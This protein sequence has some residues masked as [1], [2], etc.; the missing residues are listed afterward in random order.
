MKDTLKLFVC[1]ALC[2][3][4]SSR[5]LGRQAKET[6]AVSLVADSTF[7]NGI[8][9]RGTNS[10]N[11]VTSDTFKPFSDALG[12]A[13][14]MLSEWGSSHPLRTTVATG[15]D[16]SVSY[17]NEGKKITFSRSENGTGIEMEIFTSREF[18]AARKSGEDWP[19]LLL[20]QELRPQLRV[21]SITSLMLNLNAQLMY[22][23]NR[24][25][26][27][28]FD[29][30]IHTAQFS[31]YLAVNNRNRNSP[32]YGDYVWF[33]VPL[34]DYR[35]K[36]I[37]LYKAKDVGKADATGR[38]IY[39]I[40]GRSAYQGSF[41][42]QNWKHI[43][44]DLYP[45]IRK[46]FE[47]AK[48]NGYLT[49]SSWE[50]MYI[51]GMNIG[52]EVPGTFDAGLQLEGLSLVATVKPVLLK[53]RINGTPG[54]DCD[55]AGN[56]AIQDALESIHDASP[57][58]PY[59][60]D[61]GPG[62]YK[63]SQP[64]DFNSKGSSTGNYAF[65]RGK[66][67]VSLRGINKDS[68][69]VRGQLPDNL[70]SSFP[71]ESYQTVYWNARSG[72]ISNIT[73]T[74]KNIRYPVHIDG[75]AT[76]LSGAHIR[77]EHVNLLHY[78]NTGNA[79]RWKSWH[80]LG[81]GMSEGQVVEVVSSLLQSP[82]WPLYMHT[83]GDFKRAS[84]LLFSNCCFDGTGASKLLACF[85]SLGSHR[86]DMIR[87][88][89][90]TWKKGYVMQ[91]DDV[92]YLSDRKEG[93]HYDHCDLKITGRG[94]G[95]FLWSPSF[96]GQVLKIISRATEGG[97]VM[98]DTL[99]S[100]YKVIMQSPEE[101]GRQTLA[102]G[103]VLAGGYASRKGMNAVKAYARGCVDV[104][105]MPDMKNRY[106]R[107]LGKRLGNCSQ[108]PKILGIMIDGR[109]YEIIF[110][111]DYAG[112]GALND[113]I[114]PAFSNE[115]ILADI[116]DAIGNVADIALWSAG[117]NYYPA[118]TDNI[119]NGTAAEL[120]KKGMV[121]QMNSNR[122]LIPAMPGTRNILGVALDDMLPGEAGRVLT[123]GYL[124]TNNQ[125]PFH[126]L[127]SDK[128]RIEKG[129]A[130]KISPIPGILTISDTGGLFHAI[131]ENLIEI[132]N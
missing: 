114:P 86:E 13:C 41:H 36:H 53:V 11:P 3:C 39:S 125:Q 43:A 40:A 31:L 25:K 50:D 109:R 30:K 117:N 119:S 103:E 46:A 29:P 56:R 131:E 91:A 85:Q 118:F 93:I 26:S 10:G 8:I 38:F 44:K 22:C 94:N 99:S 62:V 120:I 115:K 32:G 27:Q 129:T 100:A 14:W 98:V 12:P 128:T 1:L 58:K 87:L 132:R 92:P 123:K 110:N 122:R 20:E 124:S 54:R 4:N 108:Q 63:A 23:N 107:S 106:N 45:E 75:G 60:I 34:Y 73:I 79:T 82:S 72:S 52:W 64:D 102:A 88:E 81:L 96:H 7:G 76:G 116:R 33:G 2:A 24:M 67:D 127:L 37:N 69:I 49:A 70:G 101:I 104:E 83:N 95:P 80:P 55:F 68:V 121:V 90:C 48:H 18:H 42:D 47:T 15:N 89:N 19:H 130:L 111:K 17:S 6:I 74:A 126:L 113:T 61:V 9:L 77:L 5:Q 78:G 59:V 28:E 66:D 65:I 16:T 84:K 21:D 105:D 97:S 57:A 35:Y 51:T 71:Y 112:P